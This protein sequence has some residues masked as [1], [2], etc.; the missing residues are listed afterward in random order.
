MNRQWRLSVSLTMISA[1][2]LGTL[3]CSLK[4]PHPAKSFYTISAEPPAEVRGEDVGTSLRI[5]DVRIARPFDAL[6]FHYRVGKDQFEADYY[7]NFITAPSHIFTGELMEWAEG[8]A[9]YRVVVGSQSSV[10]TDHT[11]ECHVL[12]LYGDYS[13]Q[14]NQVAVVRA[15]FFLLDESEVEAQV[16]L[17]RDIDAVAPIEGTGAQALVDAWGTCLNRIFDELGTELRS[18]A[19][20]AQPE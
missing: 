9:P 7:A 17:S 14:G 2:V 19:Q 11:L 6:A 10:G 15:K 5:A 20:I 12:E 3:G 4:Q 1:V 8:Q 18:A 13:D 16:L